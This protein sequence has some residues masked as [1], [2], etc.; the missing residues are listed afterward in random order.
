MRRRRG[1]GGGGGG[2]G[3]DDDDDTVCMLK[4]FKTI[5][6]YIVINA[7]CTNMYFSLIPFGN[8]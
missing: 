2:S 7:L 5:L 6:V 3:G 1:G 4:W 8:M